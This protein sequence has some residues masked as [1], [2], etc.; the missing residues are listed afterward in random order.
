MSDDNMDEIVDSIIHKTYHKSSSNIFHGLSKNKVREEVRKTLEEDNYKC[1]KCHN[2][3]TDEQLILI[4]DRP[5]EAFNQDIDAVSSD[6]MSIVCEEC[7][8]T[9]D[10]VTIGF[11]V[12]NTTKTKLGDRLVS[13][14][15]RFEIFT[16]N[17]TPSMF[18]RKNM[19]IFLL[20][21]VTVSIGTMLYGHFTSSVDGL[22]YYVNSIG[23]LFGIID[24]IVVEYTILTFIF[25]FIVTLLYVLL[26]HYQPE[27]YVDDKFHTDLT[28]FGI[29]IEYIHFIIILFL[30]T[31]FIFG[32]FALMEF[33]HLHTFPE[34]VIQTVSFVSIIIYLLVILILPSVIRDM[35]L[36]DKSIIR[37]NSQNSKIGEVAEEQD[38]IVMDEGTWVTNAKLLAHV[39][40]VHQNKGGLTGDDYSSILVVF[41]ANLMSVYVI[42]VLIFNQYI[43]DVVGTIIISIPLLF[44]VLFMQYRKYYRNKAYKEMEDTVEDID[45]EVSVKRESRLE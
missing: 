39:K 43:S 2:T 3:H 32:S 10:D 19:G 11:S 36:I 17:N 5:K 16:Q 24:T 18:I 20:A 9:Y 38:D 34:G 14:I 44:S 35:T 30:S 6:N 29:T 28:L 31:I 41:F 15:E 42:T 45:A 27:W 13:T 12:E 37:A 25:L 26:E 4:F 1:S 7:L 23:T 22:T 8:D 40:S 21:L 33:S